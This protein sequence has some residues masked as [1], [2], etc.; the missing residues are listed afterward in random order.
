[1]GMEA[2]GR[3]IAM[4]LE[5]PGED[6]NLIEIERQAGLGRSEDGDVLRHFVVGSGG[7][8][9]GHLGEHVSAH[10]ALAFGINADLVGN[11]HIDAAGEQPAG[12]ALG[13]AHQP[14]VFHDH[15]R[16]FG[17]RWRRQPFQPERAAW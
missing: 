10:D 9:V 11:I 7:F 3:L 8:G 2:E 15:R 17:A 1:M 12:V 5:A 6:A 16:R 4:A 14:P 13:V